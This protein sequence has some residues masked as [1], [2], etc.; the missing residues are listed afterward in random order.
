MRL[1]KGFI[2]GPL[3]YW[4]VGHVVWLTVDDRPVQDTPPFCMLYK[5]AIAKRAS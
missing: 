4:A 2:S 1:C 3:R 5:M